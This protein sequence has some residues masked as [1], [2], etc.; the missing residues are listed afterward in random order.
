M[1]DI[2]NLNNGQSASNCPERWSVRLLFCWPFLMKT[3]LVKVCSQNIL[4]IFISVRHWSPSVGGKKDYY[5]WK[6]FNYAI[7]PF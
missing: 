4:I 1:T 3:D 2:G 7:L 5:I 6:Q